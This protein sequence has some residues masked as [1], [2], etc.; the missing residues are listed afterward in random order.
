MIIGTIVTTDPA[1]VSGQLTVFF[2]DSKVSPTGRVRLASLLE[3]RSGQRKSFQALRNVK[4]TRVA[5]A[6]AA[7]GKIILQRIRHSPAPS[8]RA[9]S[10]TLSGMLAKNCRSRKMPKT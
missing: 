5:I 2:R 8:S 6:G 9:A 4:I 7:I 1:I 10:T 3:I